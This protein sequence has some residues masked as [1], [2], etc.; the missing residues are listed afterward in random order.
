M[1]GKPL[2]GVL[3]AH[4]LGLIPAHAGKT[5]LYRIRTYP[6][7]AHPRACGEN[8]EGQGRC[9]RL[10]GSSPRMRGKHSHLRPLGFLTRLI[11]AHAGKTS[12]VQSLKPS[13][14]AHP[15]ACGENTETRAGARGEMGSSPRMRGKLA[16]CMLHRQ[17]RGLIP[18]HAGKTRPRSGPVCAG[19]AHPRACGENGRGLCVVAEHAGSSPRMRGKPSSHEFDLTGLGL[20]PA[21]A[22][23]TF[24]KC[25]HYVRRWA[26]PRACGENRGSN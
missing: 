24:V 2:L 1:R 14:R 6:N 23:K 20:I 8:P 11:P 13:G 12:R 7:W 22:G 10:W 16:G 25:V 19:R 17:S 15:R 4:S 5:V 26:H 21:H 3:L 18:A 9:A